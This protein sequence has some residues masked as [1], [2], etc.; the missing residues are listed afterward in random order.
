M[1]KDFLHFSQNEKRGL[2]VLSTLILLVLIVNVTMPFWLKSEPVDFSVFKAEVDAYYNSLEQEKDVAIPPKKSSLTPTPF[3]IDTVSKQWLIDHGLDTFIAS[4]LISYRNKKGGFFA[5]EEVAKVYGM[6][7]SIMRIWSPFMVFPK[8]AP[9]AEET[10]NKIPPTEINPNL[11]I[12]PEFQIDI[13]TADTALF[14]LLYGIGPAFSNRIIKYRN[15]LGGFYSI[16]QI[17]EVY[18]MDSVRFSKI[19]PFLHLDTIPLRKLE[20]NIA[21][22]KTLKNHPYINFYQAK[23]MYEFRK[24]HII[25]NW[26]MLVSIEKLDTSHLKMA[27]PYLGFKLP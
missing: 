19:K 7:D 14:A 11:A 24:K 25:E 2:L 18:G 6:N 17:R 1:W 16:Q 9:T 13:N 10:T 15:L 12:K 21:S 4:N 26:N 23:A 20:L 22:L 8:Q 27:K 3:G 5:P